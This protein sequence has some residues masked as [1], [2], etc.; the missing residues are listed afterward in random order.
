MSKGFRAAVGANLLGLF[1]EPLLEASLAEMLTATI[2]E[3]RFDQHLGAD[4]TLVVIREI[5][6]ELILRH[7]LKAASRFHMIK[8]QGPCTM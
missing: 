6:H 4:H 3:V 1:L 2:C 7:K 5:L 8:N